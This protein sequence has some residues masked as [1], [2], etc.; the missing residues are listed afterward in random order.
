VAKRKDSEA[1]RPPEKIYEKKILSFQNLILT[2]T[3][4]LNYKVNPDG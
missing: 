4:W 3:N 2:L 1:K